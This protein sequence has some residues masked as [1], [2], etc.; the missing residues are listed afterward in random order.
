VLDED[1]GEEL[2]DACISGDFEQAESILQHESMY[3]NWSEPEKS[4]SI[5]HTLAYHDMLDACNL[6]LRYGADPNISNCND[7]TPLFWAVRMNCFH[8]VMTLLENGADTNVLDKSG[9]SPLHYACCHAVPEVIPLLLSYHCNPD[10]RDVDGKTAM[11]SIEKEM[12]E[13]FFACTVLIRRHLKGIK[14]KALAHEAFADPTFESVDNVNAFDMLSTGSRIAND[15]RRSNKKKFQVPRSLSPPRN[16]PVKPSFIAGSKTYYLHTPNSHSQR[17]NRKAIMTMTGKFTESE[18]EEKLASPDKKPEN[19]SSPMLEES[20]HRSFCSLTNDA[21]DDGNVNTNSEGEG[22]EEVIDEVESESLGFLQPNPNKFLAL[23]TPAVRNRLRQFDPKN[24][25]KHFSMPFAPDS[26]VA[27]RF[28]VIIAVEH[29]YNC[30]LHG[31]SVRHDKRKYENVADECLQSVV[32]DVMK[33][34]G[35]LRVFGLKS[36]AKSSRIGALEVSVS[37]F[38]PSRNKNSSKEQWQWKCLSIHSKLESKCWPKVKS[39]RTQASDFIKEM[40]DTYGYAPLDELQDDTPPLEDLKSSTKKKPAT[41]QSENYK[42]MVDLIRPD[43]LYVTD[44]NK[45]LKAALALLKE[46]RDIRA[47]SRKE[48]DQAYLRWVDRTYGDM[49]PLVPVKKKVLPDMENMFDAKGIFLQSPPH[50][51]RRDYICWSH[52][53]LKHFLIYDGRLRIQHDNILYK[54]Q[55]EFNSSDA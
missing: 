35:H 3:A 49:A 26:V 8:V 1:V 17:M 23:E 25:G 6:L 11:E 40:L 2:L 5:L 14:K 54:A 38:L 22:G 33:N 30:H 7:E 36:E 52:A 42:A 27:E 9:S 37:M 20:M 28:D 44:S 31:A 12:D 51:D 13:D 48:I 46:K 24:I 47:V 15:H 32:S 16:I 4:V 55:M 50:T 19:I 18:I 45:D 29:C 41:L 10:I 43:I 34:C 53:N 39:I 21:N